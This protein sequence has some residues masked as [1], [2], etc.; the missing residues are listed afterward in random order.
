MP[1]IYSAHQGLAYGDG[2]LQGGGELGQ[3]V[4]LV[5]N[6]LFEVNTDPTQRSFGILRKSYAAGEM[7]GVFCNGGVLVT[8]VYEGTPAAGDLLKVASSGYL[9]PGV[10]NNEQAV[11]E[12]ISVQGRLLKLKLLV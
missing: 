3:V 1:T 5:G 10:Q 7:P 11:A 12:V 4:R 2:Y 6:D 8:D 9:T